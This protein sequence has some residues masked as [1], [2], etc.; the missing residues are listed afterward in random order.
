VDGVKGACLKAEQGN[1]DGRIMAIPPAPRPLTIIPR[2]PQ[3]RL[4]I[5]RVICITGEL[6]VLAMS[7]VAIILIRS[8]GIVEFVVGFNLALILVFIAIVEL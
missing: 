1:A 6:V 5:A 8:T 7:I 3:T 4:R 2:P